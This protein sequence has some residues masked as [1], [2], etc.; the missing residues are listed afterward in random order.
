MAM[1]PLTRRAIGLLAAQ[2]IYTAMGEDKQ[3]EFYVYPPMRLGGAGSG[4]DFEQARRIVEEFVSGASEA[5]RLIVSDQTVTDLRKREKAIEVRYTSPVLLRFG[6]WFG[7]VSR[8]FVPLS[9]KLPDGVV[10]YVGSLRLTLEEAR[11]APISSS[12]GP[13]A[14]RNKSGT[15]RLKDDLRSAGLSF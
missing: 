12:Y 11:S 14:L 6:K 4:P 3:F 13:G 2:C 10:L 9:G 7:K 5:F 15:S 1:V 8:L